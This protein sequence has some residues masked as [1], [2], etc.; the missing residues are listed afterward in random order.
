LNRNKI[1]EILG[2]I[3]G[4]VLII[5]YCLNSYGLLLSAS[6]TYQGLNLFGSLTL[7]YYTYQKKAYPNVML[8]VIWALIAMIAIFRFLT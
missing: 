7:A 1:L 4:I 3:G 8:N 2:W 5:A 6:V